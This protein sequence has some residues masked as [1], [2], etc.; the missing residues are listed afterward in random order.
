M[1]GFFKLLFYLL[2]SVLGL[3]CYTSFSLVAVGGDDSLVAMHE[4]LIGVA[5]LVTEHRI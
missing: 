4:V 3:C 2:L 5:L 1:L